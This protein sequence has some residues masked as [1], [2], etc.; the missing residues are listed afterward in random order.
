[1]PDASAQLGLQYAETLRQRIAD[2][3]LR[4][5]GLGFAMTI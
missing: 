4:P 3:H 1:M 2:N 5:E